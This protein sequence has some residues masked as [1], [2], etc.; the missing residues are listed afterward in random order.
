MTVLNGLGAEQL[1]IAGL[2]G[3]SCQEQE[4]GGEGSYCLTEAVIMSCLCSFSTLSDMG[5]DSEIFSLTDCM[6][7]QPALFLSDSEP[8][9]ASSKHHARRRR[10]C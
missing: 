2:Y 4:E 1:N 6:S 3:N 8:S 7:M 5:N 9:R 10:H